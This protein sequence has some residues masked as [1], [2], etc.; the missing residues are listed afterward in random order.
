MVFERLEE[1]FRR[2]IH[3][4]Q[5]RLLSSSLPTRYTLEHVANLEGSQGD[6]WKGFTRSYGSIMN[7]PA[8]TVDVYYGSKLVENI[9]QWSQGYV[10]VPDAI[11][12]DTPIVVLWLF[13]AVLLVLV[14][15]FTVTAN[16]QLAAPRA[17][18]LFSGAESPTSQQAYAFSITH[19]LREEDL[20]ALLGREKI[21][22]RFPHVL[23]LVEMAALPAIKALVSRTQDVPAEE[24]VLDRPSVMATMQTISKF[25]QLLFGGDC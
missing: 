12:A 25:H 5:A 6:F 13:H 19:D 22:R 2:L 4:N 17:A 3:A 16:T 9:K 14:A 10:Q 7:I 21:L 24:S 18:R 15:K 8:E 1:P 20:R 11:S 23:P